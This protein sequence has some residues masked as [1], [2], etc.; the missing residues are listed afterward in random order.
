[1]EQLQ[2]TNIFLEQSKVPF[3]IIDLE[4]QLLYSNKAYQGLT[5]VVP[6]LT[7]KLNESIFIEDVGKEDVEKW[8]A[9]YKRA[10]KGA[11]FEAENHYYNSELKETQYGQTTFE[12]LKNE[13]NKIYAVACQWKNVSH[14]V[15]HKSEAKQ[16]MDSSLD[17]FCTFNEQGEFLYVSEAAKEHWGYSP[18]ELL[19]T[20]YRSL[21][22]EEDLSA[23]DSIDTTI[24]NGQ[25]IKSFSNRYRK[26]D[27]GIAYNIWSSK[28]D[29]RTKRFY[30]VA[31]DGKEK[32]EQEEKLLKSE[33]RFKALVTGAFDLVAV[34]DIKG[35][36]LYMSP[37]ITA[38]AGIPPEV[39]IGKN[40]FDFVHPDDKK[41][42]AAELEKSIKE[43]RV[44]M[45]PYRAKNHKNEWRWVESILTNMLDNSAINGIVINSRDITEKIEQ[46]EKL[47]Q[48]ERRFKALIQEGSDLIGILDTDGTYSY[49]SPTSNA[50]LGISP[51][52]FIGRNAFEFIHPN[53]EPRVLAGLQKVPTENKVT[54]KPYRF[55]NHKKEWRWVE[56]VLTN[57]LDNPSV[58]GIVA[59]SRDVTDRIEQE[60][61]IVQTEKRFE[62]LI[63]NSMDCIVILSPEGE[64]NFVSEAIKN[65]L[66]YTPSEIMKMDIWELIHPEDIKGSQAAL[67]KSFKQPG[68]S[69]EGFTARLKHKDGSWRWVEP[70][71]TNLVHDPSIRGIVDVFRDVT[72]RKTEELE[73]DLINR[74]SDIFNQN[75]HNELTTCL[76]SVCEQ[77]VH[78]DNFSFAEIW[79]PTFDSKKLNRAASYTGSK[80]GKQFFKESKKLNAVG[81]KEGLSDQV[82]KNRETV[83]WESV[84][85]EWHLFKRK[86]AAEKAGIKSLIAIPLMHNDNLLG[87]LLIG[88][89][90]AKSALSMNLDLFLKL[91]STIGSELSRKKTE[92]ELSQ[93]FNFTPD[94][95]CVAGFDGYIKQ[96]NPAGLALLGYSLEEIRSR[97]IKSFV[98]E[99]DKSL[100]E[101]NQNK[102]YNGK[103][104]DSFENRYIT[105]AGKVIW[106]SWTATSLPE[107]GIIYAV[108]KDITEEKNLRELNRHVGLLAKIGSWEVD[109]VK[110]TVFWSDEVHKIYETDPNSFVP[111]VDNAIDFY[112][113]D[114]R[115]FA[116]SS[117]EKC[118]ETGESYEI[119]AVIVTC[120]NKERWVRTTAKAEFIDGACVRVYGSFQDINERK[121]AEN[122]LQSLADNIPGIIYNYAIYPDGTDALLHVSGDVEKIWGFTADQVIEN[123]KLIWDQIKLGGDFEEVQASVQK[124]IQTKSKWI[125]RSKYVS[126][127]GEV[128]NLLGFGSP[129]F[130]ADGTILF[131]SII[132]DNTQQAK[133]EE[134]LTS[135]GKL[136]K[137][138]GWEVDLINNSVYW[139]KE[140]HLIHKT[141]PNFFIPTF[142]GAINF[143]REDF[144]DLV[145]SNVEECIRTGD[146]YKIEA[147]LITA[148]KKELWVR[149]NA[150]AEFINGVCTRIYGSIQD[151][152]EQKTAALELER[153]IKA[154]GDYKYSLDQSAII[155]FTDQKGVITS[156]NDNFC[157]ISGYSKKE[158]L[159]K[160]HRIINA[161]YH[162]ASFFKELWKTIASGKVWR[163]EVKNKAK[164]GSYYWVDTTITPFLND[165]NKPVQYLAIRFDITER[166]KAEDEKARFQETLENSLNEIYMF[167]SKTF[168][169]G[170]VN[171]GAMLNLGYTKQE[172]HDLTPLDIKPEYTEESFNQLVSPLL[173]HE[174]E[175]VIFFTEHKRKDGSLYPV[176]VHLKLV[177]EAD[178]SNFIAII[179]DI[180]ER[181]KAE[182]DLIAS[183]ERLR[184]ATK[185]G[186]IGIWDWDVVNDHLIWDD[187]MY[188]IFD[189][190]ENEFQ[191]AF[192]A[193]EAKIHPDDV[194]EANE[195]LQNA[196]KGLSKFN[197]EFRV[198]RH[199][200]SIRYVAGEAIVIRD[201]VSGNPIRMIG[202]NIDITERKKAE[203][204]NRF[205]ANLLSMVRQG[206]IATNLEGEVNYW[207]K[208]AEIMYG[209]KAEEA[210]GKNIMQLTTLENNEEEARKIM[211]MLKKGESWSG[212]FEV[213]K[214]DGTNFTVKITNSPIYDGKK[215]LRGI[216]GISTDITQEIKNRELLKQYTKE[217]ERSNEELEQ[218][219]F[220][221]SHDLQEPLR[222][223]S[224]FMDQLKR[225]YEDQLD[226]KALQ[227]IY[228]ATD[229]AKR[230]KNIILDLL[231]YSRASKP[232]DD[233]EEVNLNEVI[234]S[235]EQLRRKVI[236]ESS[237]IIKSEE[238]PSIVTYNAVVTQI[239]H[240]LLDNSIKY[241]REGIAPVIEIKSQE[242]ENEW[243]FSVTDNGI[244]IDAQFYDKIFVI[245]QRLHNRESYA[246]TGIGL[247]IVKRCVEFLDGKIWLTSTVGEGTTFFFTIAKNRKH[248]IQKNE[249]S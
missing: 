193:W 187:T 189:V 171:K 65:I 225:K 11:S 54:L 222:M 21:V 246:G 46:E 125:S 86:A 105:K 211:E 82:L 121:Q 17:V 139:T 68:V 186:N 75:T 37:S 188:D 34:I 236:A 212:N 98:H 58:K 238:L 80:A 144:H 122:R 50:V 192:E 103:D 136:A 132:L 53:D 154:L 64:T 194:D 73:K 148:N 150:S 22:I 109:L 27:G 57:M 195:E 119:E 25:E 15:N 164:N 56:T 5:K 239:F 102:L 205:K 183:S 78:F 231:D 240:G 97:P 166:K 227:Y 108:A 23:T 77:V 223:I 137:I 134:L 31:R 42:T 83:I 115:Q 72:K 232:S 221:T 129:S 143:Y 20:P 43:D 63:Q 19:G 10:F 88:T 85:E 191:G 128:R 138:G 49:V 99:E 203:K 55:L 89:E 110:Q 36:Y 16:L 90:K 160:T 70:V 120:S 213:Q 147:V 60:E 172:L 170:Y 59:N 162:P 199:D 229:G 175:K 29:E 218:F 228:F 2:L 206:A 244:G 174:K 248:K 245:F 61:R 116:L 182:E 131:N 207:N 146:P 202:T 100:T 233:L 6:G 249:I 71:V 185:T 159:G 44:I 92:V 124:S 247:A 130:L 117:F 209:W 118:I 210:L 197:A 104:L 173:S 33:K 51:E 163:G 13:E 96:I 219:A 152:H 107:Q 28:W 220:V 87:G 4:F 142:E 200:K 74:I 1:M 133:N 106:L 84:D 18:A 243:K 179:L 141:D 140:T 237:T 12:P 14:I 41:Q 47:L 35:H 32:L 3:W 67:A 76:S 214:K 7:N 216:I 112:R 95:I 234:T 242:K 241:A 24:R 153:S 235:Y 62:T 52:E 149:S 145:R 180:T 8:A 135:T 26:K 217:L 45:K 39:F 38:I 215:N 94:M 48:S 93:I 91:E 230:M 208:G 155:A 169:F 161:S 167:D 156:V 151:I 113:E 158:L 40:A 9:Y 198:V 177:E 181:K 69:I 226:D 111:T 176:E 123:S 201:E 126:P 127:T 81:I 79:L 184:L 196:L 168:K 165:K 30:S 204:E 190:E 114:F 178:Y 224:G 101:E 66:G 157:E